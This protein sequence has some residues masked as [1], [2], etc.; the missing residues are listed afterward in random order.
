[1]QTLTLIGIGLIGGSVAADIKRT[2]DIYIYGVDASDEHLRTAIDHKLIDQA[3]PQLTDEAANADMVMIATPV[4]A[5][6]QVMQELAQRTQNTGNTVITDVGSTKQSTIT[7]FQ[8]FL[9]Q[10][11]PYCVAAHPIAGSHQSGA[12]A[13]QLGLFANKKVVLCPHD[14]QHS[15]SLKKVADLWQR[16]GAKVFSMSAEEHDRI[17]AAVSHLPHLLSFA[18]M[19][20]I[21]QNKDKTQL[22]DFAAT[23]FRDFTRLAGS[24]P[25][26]WT[27]ICLA[28]TKEILSCLNDHQNALQQLE[29]LL[30]NK[31]KDALHTFFSQAQNIRQAWENK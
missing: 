19:Q 29:N 6:T 12:T 18:F 11:L 9:P 27:E 16:I 15:G 13:A 1:M 25:D 30:K 14:T 5:M 3:L 20:Q 23:G 24:N 28:N 10:H 17:F 7:A 2:S 4:M 8:H 21:A 31:D 22:L 26:V